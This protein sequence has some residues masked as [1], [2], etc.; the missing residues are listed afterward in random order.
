MLQLLEQD[1][2]SLVQDAGPI[3]SILAEVKDLLTPNL[4]L[5]L[6]LAAYIK[7]F[8]PLILEAKRSI[9]H[10][11]THQSQKEKDR[12]HA[13]EIKQKISDI[14]PSSAMISV[15]LDRLKIKEAE[16]LR[17][18]QKTQDAIASETSRL[19]RVPILVSQAK[20]EYSAFTR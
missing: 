5:V 3:R 20:D 15:E 16:Q 14:E 18:L 19:E 2:D 9:A 12:A 11:A 7:G 17:E 4:A 13:K 8:E 6:A 10:H 1:L